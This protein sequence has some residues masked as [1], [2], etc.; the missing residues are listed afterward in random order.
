MNVYHKQVELLLSVLPYI[1]KE[2]CFALKGGTAIN[3]FVRDMPRLSVDIDLQYVYLNDRQT[4]FTEINGALDRIT[5]SINKTPIQAIIRKG[6]DSICKIICS[7]GYISIKIE[8]NYIIRGCAFPT[9]L[10]QTTSKVQQV[11][12]FAA[13][14]VLSFGELYGGKICAALDR[15]HPRDLFDVKYL[16]KNEGIT[17]QI[18]VGFLI[19]LLGHNRPPHEILSPNLQDHRHILMKEFVGMSKEDFSYD[20]HVYTFRQ[21][22]RSVND[23]LND[24][25]RSFIVDFFSGRPSWEQFPIKILRELPAIKWKQRNLQQ[26]K[27]SNPEKFFKQIKELSKILETGASM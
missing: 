25:D 16:L 27:S 10:I 19:S 11:Y 4:A 7:D 1:S 5:Q 21:L 3:L 9:Q 15:Q 8:P 24:Q 23:A 17:T 20:E 14:N 13:M 26:L 18:K 6:N 22:I 2:K 12:G